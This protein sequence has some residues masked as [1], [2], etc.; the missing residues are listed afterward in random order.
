MATWRRRDDDCGTTALATGA[1]YAQGAD[2]ARSEALKKHYLE[3][4]AAASRGALD[5]DGMMSC[6]V[7]YEVLKQ[8]VFDALH[9]W[10]RQARDG[11]GR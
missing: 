5:R 2:G 3:C 8:R 4:E 11:G 10:W 9:A 6:S 1:A 7:V